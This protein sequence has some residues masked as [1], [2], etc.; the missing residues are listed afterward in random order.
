[1]TK[2]KTDIR[3]I[4][5]IEYAHENDILNLMEY[6]KQQNAEVSVYKKIKPDSIAAK[7]TICFLSGLSDYEEIFKKMIKNGIIFGE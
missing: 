2:F 3:L 4:D 1:M 5:L 6:L 7:T